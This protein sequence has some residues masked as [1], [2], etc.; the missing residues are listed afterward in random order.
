VSEEIPEGEKKPAPPRLRVTKG[1]PWRIDPGRRA[2]WSAPEF[3]SRSAVEVRQ[4]G[5]PVLHAPA[6]KPRLGRPELEALVE[7]MFASMVVAHGIGI[8][9]P[10][11]GV[12]LRVVILDVDEAGIV[13]IEPTIEWTSDEK[14]ET[15]EGCL[16]VKGMYGML[17]RPVAARLVATDLTGKRFTVVGDEFGAQCMLHET[18]HL[19]GTLYVDRLR[20]RED[21]HT[22]EPEEEERVSA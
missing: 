12:P 16:S 13:A 9:A 21:L 6:K 15:S 22:V 10:Q 1:T 4:I 2:K 3:L 7:R 19:N 11:I 20:S 18:D 8:A 5:D 17:E 14:E